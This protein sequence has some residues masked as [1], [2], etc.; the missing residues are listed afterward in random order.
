MFLDPSDT[1]LQVPSS[2]AGASLPHLC[3]PQAAWEP[4]GSL[5]HCSGPVPHAPWLTTG[6]SV[7]NY[8]SSATR[9]LLGCNITCWEKP[10]RAVRP[11]L[12]GGRMQPAPHVQFGEEV[13]GCV[14]STHE[15]VLLS[16]D[17]FLICESLLMR[18]MP[19]PWALP[20]SFMIQVLDGLFRNSSTNRL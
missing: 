13:G 4:S 14:F 20:H 1:G 15:D 5:K 9:A 6:T 11:S 2:A 18:K 16:R 12:Q 10:T 7:A 17:H 19:F 3:Q 8:V